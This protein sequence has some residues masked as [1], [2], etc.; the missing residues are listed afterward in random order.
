[1]GFRDIMLNISVRAIKVTLGWTQKI[2]K[3]TK[4]IKIYCLDKF[5]VTLDKILDCEPK[6]K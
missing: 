4:S 3:I 6:N 1:M 2:G 5:I